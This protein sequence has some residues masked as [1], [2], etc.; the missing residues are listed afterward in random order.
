MEKKKGRPDEVVRGRVSV[1]NGSKDRGCGEV[2]Q[3]TKQAQ[4]LKRNKP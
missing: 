1:G 4:K 2:S 3:C